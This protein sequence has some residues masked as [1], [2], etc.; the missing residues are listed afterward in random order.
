MVF[1]VAS[2][3][4]ALDTVTAS[5]V[6]VFDPRG[7]YRAFISNGQAYPAFSLD[8]RQLA[9][10]SPRQGNSGVEVFDADTALL[11]HALPDLRSTPSSRASLHALALSA[12]GRKVAGVVTQGSEWFLAAWEMAT[13]D[14][15]VWSRLRAPV[16]WMGFAGGGRYI[17]ARHYIEGQFGGERAVKVYD[18]TT[19]HFLHRLPDDPDAEPG[20]D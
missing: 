13:G 17:V 7:Q 10:L 12:D 18:G 6:T 9:M 1:S 11:V 8:G 4:A 16:T 5:G 14:Q 20:A 2:G 19:G 3:L 15:R